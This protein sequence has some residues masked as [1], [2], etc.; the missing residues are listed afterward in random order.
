MLLQKGKKT[1]FEVGKWFYD[2]RT[3]MGFNLKLNL[4]ILGFSTVKGI[5]YFKTSMMVIYVRLGFKNKKK[6]FP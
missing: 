6:N 5:E 1:R 4:W 3:D 2:S